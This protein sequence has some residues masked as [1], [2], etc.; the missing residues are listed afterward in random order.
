ME[1]AGGLSVW[2]RSFDELMYGWIALQKVELMNGIKTFIMWG[3]NP[4]LFVG[5]TKS[6]TWD[7]GWLS[8]GV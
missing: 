7:F 4:V 8:F 3:V 6:M 5:L 2:N 1:K